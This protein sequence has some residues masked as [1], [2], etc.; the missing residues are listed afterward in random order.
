MSTLHTPRIEELLPAYALDALDGDDLLELE[1]HLAGDC[2]ECR[3]QLALWQGDLEELA[4]AVTPVEPS[5]ITRARILRL[6]G[7]SPAP[8]RAVRRAS[9]WLAAAALVLLGLAVW[10]FA[11]QRQLRDEVRSLVAEHDRLLR[12]VEM[13]STQMSRMKTDTVE[14]KSL[15]DERDRLR[16]EVEVLNREMGRRQTEA[17]QVKQ[18]LQ[19]LA[20]PGVKSVALAGLGPAPGA[21]GRTYV[22]PST[23]SALFYAFDLPALSDEKTYELWFI[24]GGKPVSAGT[25]AVDAYGRASLRVDRVSDVQRIE[26]WAVTV[27]P[28]GGVPKPTGAFV[29]KGT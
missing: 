11:G 20:A 23:H 9:G 28:R 19:V 4:A 22:N 5:E 12:Q 17:L 8:A 26:A 18:D 29:L 6:A 14:A 24:A 15:L 13:L 16:H 27:E 10:G 1:E 3:R 21:Q 2:D 7:G 25:F